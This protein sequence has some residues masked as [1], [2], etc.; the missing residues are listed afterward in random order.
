MKKNN[1]NQNQPTNTKAIIF[2]M[3]LLFISLQIGF[4]PTYLKYFPAF[5]QFNWLHHTHGVLMVSWMVMLVLQPFLIL[6]GKYSI[7]RL[8]GKISYIIAPLMIISMF[9][10]MRMGYLSTVNKIDFKEVAELQAVTIIELISFAIFYLLAIINKKDIAKHKRYMIASSFP[11]IMAIFS[12]I[13]QHSFGTAIE[14]Y[15]FFIPLY[16]SVLLSVIFLINDILK[17]SNPIPYTI[18]TVVILLNI[19][20]FH[21]RAT[22]V[23][24]ALVRFVG[25]TIY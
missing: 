5:N 10:V 12:R 11:M 4:H 2:G 8:I 23:W 19:I 20:N 9:L 25:D 1:T 15:D 16:V 24:L 14:P 6:K 17:E 21:A 22:E 13:L 18:V 3:V 7:H